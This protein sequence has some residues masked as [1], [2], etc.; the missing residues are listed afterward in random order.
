MGYIE[1][2]LSLVKAM[3]SDYWRSQALAGIVPY[4]GVFKRHR[5]DEF[6]MTHSVDGYSFALDFPVTKRNREGLQE[7]TVKLNEVVLAAG[8]RF[9]FAKDS[10][11]DRDTAEAY[12]G[13][14]TIQRFA[15]L[16]RKYDPAG[17]LETDLS[18]RLF[19][20]WGA[21]RQQNV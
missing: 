8:G 2:A 17:V 18:R 16:K 14:E 20:D 1:K 4:L 10:S 12:L 11:L 6:L 21:E 15:E 7:L 5:K 3:P 9:Y 19:G 13:A